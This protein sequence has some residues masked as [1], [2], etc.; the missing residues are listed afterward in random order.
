MYVRGDEGAQVR[1]DFDLPLTEVAR[2]QPSTF[3]L[4]RNC[5]LGLFHCG[6]LIL[7]EEGSGN[8]FLQPTNR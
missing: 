5:N 4:N 8:V 2:F 1:T 3:K 6:A 7:N